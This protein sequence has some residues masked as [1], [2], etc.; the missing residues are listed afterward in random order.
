MVTNVQPVIPK[1]K[2]VANAVPTTSTGF[3]GE[4][5]SN[6]YDGK[7]YMQMNNGTA[8]VVQVGGLITATGD[9]TGSGFGTVPLTLASVGTPGTYTKLTT[10]AKGR[11]I[12]G[13]QLAAS[14]VT[15]ALTYTPVNAN[16]LGV[17]SGV[18]TLDSTAKLT[19]SQLPSS[20]VGGMNY[21]G[22]W[23]AS[24]N[25]PT[26]TSSTGTKGYFYKVSTAGS[27]TLDGI[28]IWN[29]G[30]SAVFDGSTWDKI[31]GITN[32]VISV[33]GLAGAVS[34]ATSNLS[35]V[36]ITSIAT[37]Q[38]LQWN[39]TKFVNVT[40]PNP[41][42]GTV[43]SVSSSNSAITIATP[44][45]TPALTFVPS[46]VTLQSLGGSLTVS[47]ISPSGTNGYVLSTVG[48][49]TA[50]A[51][52]AVSSVNGMTGAVTGLAPTASPTFTGSPAL[53]TATVTAP[54]AGDSS[55]YVPSTAWVNA[56]I[57]STTGGT[58]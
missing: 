48:G 36:V 34:L 25:S 47:Q 22:T 7:I 51:A 44:T 42:T 12:T 57:S 4:L 37:N 13:A 38:V 53:S 18:A 32:E 56:A 21:Q 41:G 55:T 27:T 35:D 23:N 43:T 14:D 8:S 40:L 5:I 30:D 2:A 50:W 54:G 11:V 19:A 26:L 10:D 45:S 3:L 29:V 46:A 16:Q 28:S 9:A 1:Q 33:N 52:P 24:T 20:V 31:D 49:S 58:W 6:T 15:T 39:G 17:A